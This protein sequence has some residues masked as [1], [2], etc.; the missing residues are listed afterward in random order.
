M[1]SETPDRRILIVWFWKGLSLD[2][3]DRFE[4][5]ITSYDRVL[6]TDPHHFAALMNKAAALSSLGR[7]EDSLRCYGKAVSFFLTGLRAGTRKVSNWHAS[8]V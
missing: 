7:G 4:E 1:N 5:A 6:E 2:E 3:L 8:I